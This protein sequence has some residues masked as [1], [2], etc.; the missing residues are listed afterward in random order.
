M[1]LVRDVRNLV[2]ITPSTVHEEEPLLSVAEKIVS[3]PKTQSVYVVDD[4]GKLKGI[5]P[6]MELI[7]YLY[8]SD[9][10]Q[11]Y[12]LYR[13]PVI[14]SSQAR[15]RDIMLPPVYVRDED[16]LSE[17]LIH[18]FKNNLRELPVVDEDMH[19]IGDLNI[20]ELIIAWIES[21]KNAD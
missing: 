4:D 3:E 9:I 13:F 15:A 11:E 17:A 12:I 19:V 7:Q 18:V 16:K 20:L 10:P 6:V 14:L 1:K 2:T 8:F 5:I 21:V